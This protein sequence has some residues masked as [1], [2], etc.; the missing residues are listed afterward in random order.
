MEK[1]RIVAGGHVEGS[2][3]AAFFPAT[4]SGGWKG[5]IPSTQL[6]AGLQ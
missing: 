1:E 5:V 4:V 2:L 6:H 3:D